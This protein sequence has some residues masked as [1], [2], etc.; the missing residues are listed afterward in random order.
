M[1]QGQHEA[2]TNICLGPGQCT[3]S[4]A[5]KSRKGC[6]SKLMWCQ[7]FVKSNMQIIMNEISIEDRSRTGVGLV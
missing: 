5:A 2:P 4:A 1:T 3:S 7:I 6:V